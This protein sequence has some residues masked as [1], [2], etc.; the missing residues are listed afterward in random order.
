M[1]G[2]SDKLAALYKRWEN[3]FSGEDLKII[4]EGYLSGRYSLVLDLELNYGDTLLNTLNHPRPNR[5]RE[6]AIACPLGSALY[7]IKTE[8]TATSS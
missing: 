5:A 2:L 3:R 4:G 1:K 7:P 6:H 8:T